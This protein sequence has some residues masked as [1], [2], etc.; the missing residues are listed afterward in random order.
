MPSSEQYLTHVNE[1]GHE[2]NSKI[3]DL[4]RE[5]ERLR[6]ENE[7]LRAINEVQ[8]RHLSDMRRSFELIEHHQKPRKRFLGLF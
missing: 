6:M 1:L 3:N 2:L 7:K 4:E 5:V 8:D